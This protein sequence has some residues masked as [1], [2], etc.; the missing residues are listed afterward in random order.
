MVRQFCTSV[1]QLHDWD[2]VCPPPAHDTFDVVEFRSF[3]KGAPDQTNSV[4]G[5]LVTR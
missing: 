2:A 3:V 4:I 5:P 1:S